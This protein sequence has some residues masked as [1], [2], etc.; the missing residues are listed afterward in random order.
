MLI[1]IAIAIAMVRA[2]AMVTV[3]V[4]GMVSGRGGRITLEQEIG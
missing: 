4:T 2:I 1:A 3:A